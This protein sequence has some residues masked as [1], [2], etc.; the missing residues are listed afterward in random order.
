[1][2]PLCKYILD[3]DQQCEQAAINGG[4]YCR[5]HQVVRKSVAAAEAEL[6]PPSLPLIFPTNYACQVHNYFLIA[7][8]LNEGRINLKT[9][10]M[11]H[12]LL[13]SCDASLK[14]AAL[15]AAESGEADS[16][17]DLD[18]E[19][20]LGAIDE[21]KI[22]LA[23]SEESE[24]TRKEPAGEPAPQKRDPRELLRHSRSIGG[25]GRRR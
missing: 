7:Q 21:M 9:A 25:R 18:A 4:H 23:A 20:L 14:Q 6:A 11:L 13:K 22:R 2:V 19:E 10:N 5:H 1:M 17:G 16:S 8:A 3:G 12:R 15:E 24:P